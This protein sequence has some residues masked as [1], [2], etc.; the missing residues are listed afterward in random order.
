MLVIGLTGGI[1]SGKSEVS[2]ILE[3]LGAFII[4]ADQ[5]GH[6]AYKP[7]SEVWQEV[8]GAFGEGILGP[9][10]EIDRKRLGTIVFADPQARIKLNSIVHPK[11]AKIVEERIEELRRQGADTV[12]LE[13]ALLV[14]A[15]WNSLV[16]EVWVTHA[17]EEKILGRLKRR[18]HLPDEEIRNRIKT[19]LPLR[20]K[21]KHS[22]V[23]IEN[24]ATLQDLR[25][26]VEELWQ[27]RVKEKKGSG[28][29]G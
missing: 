7:Y 2:R 25:D 19:Q 23:L 24:S 16:G 29:D 22:E 15:R 5:I 9:N 1:G 21:A 20:E 12:V 14:E 17:P 18:N 11:M 28:K 10:G 27:R 6:E 3:G 8:V 13:A 4:N 26:K